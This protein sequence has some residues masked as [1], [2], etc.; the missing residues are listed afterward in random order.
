MKGQ[1]GEPLQMISQRTKHVSELWL[2]VEI[3]LQT[4]SNKSP[5]DDLWHSHTCRPSYIHARTEACTHTH[6]LHTDTRVC[7][8]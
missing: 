5:D 2:P 7:I 6:A 8:Q 1:I 4:S 3:F